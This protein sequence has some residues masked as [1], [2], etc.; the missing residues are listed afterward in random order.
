MLSAPSLE[1]RL[2]TDLALAR[3]LRLRAIAAWLRILLAQ[4]FRVSR[5]MFRNQTSSLAL[6][7]N[8]AYWEGVRLGS[9]DEWIAREIAELEFFSEALTMIDWHRRRGHAIV[10]ISGTLA[11][12]A[13]AIGILVTEGA[14]IFV[15][16]TELE[17]NC[18]RWA[19]R[20]DG[21]AICG[22]AK[23]RALMRLAAENNFDLSRSYAYANSLNDRWLLGAAGHPIAVNAAPKLAHLARKSGWRLVNW[24]GR[25]RVP[26]IRSDAEFSD[27]KSGGQIF[28][29][30]SSW[31]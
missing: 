10:L 4:L 5:D 1:L 13:R 12:L 3:K 17:S 20:V 23:E 19:G 18:G 15:K 16:A 30:K 26:A 21:E 6:N 27:V 9:V 7:E 2:L 8:K 11:P 31:K 25:A 29:E 24:I 14:E 22:P 28:T